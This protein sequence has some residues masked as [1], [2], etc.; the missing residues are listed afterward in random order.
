MITLHQLRVFWAVAH[1]E[2][3]TRAA[4]QLGVTQPSLSQQLAKLESTLGGRLFDR[5][6]NQLVLT[7]AGRFLLRRAESVLAEIDEAEA[8]LAEFRM[9]RRGRIAVGALGSIARTIVPGAYRRTLEEYPDLELDLHELAPAEALEQLYGR[10]L[11]LALL[12]SVS[13]AAN[14]ISFSRV[15]IARDPYVFAAPKGLD[16]GCVIDPEW[17]LSAEQRRLLNRTIQFNFGNLHNQRVEDWYRRVLPRHQVAAQCRT[18]ETALAM[19]EAGLGVALVPQL[20]TQLGGR[21]THDVDLYAVPELERPIIALV[22]PQYRR[23]QPFAAFL[24]ALREAARRLVLPPVG[25]A[26]PF[27]AAARAAVPAPSAAP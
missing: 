12:S 4:K 18:Y 1:G 20:C 23:A 19:V 15:D 7:D 14:R 13:L 17:D 9:G 21:L 16:L 3:L 2:S 6:N 10:N 5:V 8:G 27:L 26:P 22:P 24:D 11:Q 25:P